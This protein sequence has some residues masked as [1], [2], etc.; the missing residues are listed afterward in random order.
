[1]ESIIYDPDNTTYNDIALCTICLLAAPPPPMESLA[2]DLQLL[3]NDSRF[4][5]VQFLVDNKTVYAH[6]AIL[7]VRSDY[8]RAM[9]CDRMRE[10]SSQVTHKAHS[11]TIAR[12]L[13]FVSSD[14]I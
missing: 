12:V 2:N 10:A 9:F 7:V 1:M 4:S 13:P 5:D 3:V 14:Y 8:F 6:K 11:E